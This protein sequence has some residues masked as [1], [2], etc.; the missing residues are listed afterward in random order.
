MASSRIVGCF[1]WP[2]IET[3]SVS[4]RFVRPDYRPFLPIACEQVR[5]DWRENNARK[6]QG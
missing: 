2:T 3:T 4:V 5:I 6:R 1:A